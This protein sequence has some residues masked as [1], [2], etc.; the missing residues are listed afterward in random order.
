MKRFGQVIRLQPGVL[1]SYKK[2]HDA[3]WPEVASKI[4]ACGLCNYSI[5]FS[6]LSTFHAISEPPLRGVLPA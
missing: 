3:I 5:L 6:M 2:Y 4:T 1:E